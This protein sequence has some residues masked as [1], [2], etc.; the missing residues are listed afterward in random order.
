MV[1]YLDALSRKCV[2]YEYILKL[3]RGILLSRN[4]LKLLVKVEDIVINSRVLIIHED[5][6]ALCFS[7]AS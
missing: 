5:Q 6:R 1:A 3:S 7:C 4:T 2:S